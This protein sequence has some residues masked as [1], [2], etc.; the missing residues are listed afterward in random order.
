MTKNP[1]QGSINQQIFPLIPER[2]LSELPE[3][4]LF[5]AFILVM[6]LSQFAAGLSVQ[7]GAARLLYGM[8]RDHALPHALFGYLS[9]STQDPTR[10]VMLVGALAFGGTLVLSLDHAVDILNFAQDRE[11]LSHATRMLSRYWSEKNGRKR[12]AISEYP[13]LEHPLVFD[14]CDC[15][16][17]RAIDQAAMASGSPALFA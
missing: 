12:A 15:V 13:L 11:W 10:N 3:P 5:L 4:P 9:P 2:F 6:S 1:S 8:G 16:R 7:V 14:L 17:S